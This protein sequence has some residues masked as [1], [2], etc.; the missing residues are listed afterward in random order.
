MAGGAVGEM[1]RDCQRAIFTQPCL[2]GIANYKYMDP[3]TKLAAFNELEPAESLATRLQS[4]GIDASVHN[5]STQQNWQLWN[6]EPRAHLHVQVRTDQEAR[7][8]E[9]LKQWVAEAGTN[10]GAVRCPDCGSFKVEYPQFSRKTLLGALPAAMA[11]AGVIERNYYCQSC[12][13]TWP[14]QPQ[15]PGPELDE[16]NWPKRQN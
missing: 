14:D 8:T 3:L 10:L 2:G 5:E 6:L 15:D 4:S 13:F 16:L 11:A 9:L 1:I 7:A 12:H